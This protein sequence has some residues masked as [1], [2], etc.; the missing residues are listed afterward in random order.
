MRLV[1]LSRLTEKNMNKLACFPEEEGAESATS[2]HACQ[3]LRSAVML[4][5]RSDGQG[6]T[7]ATGQACH[8]PFSE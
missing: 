4:A 1:G 3:L 8:D 2:I 6:S 5:A 7:P